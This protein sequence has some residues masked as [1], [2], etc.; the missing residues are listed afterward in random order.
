[1]ATEGVAMAGLLQSNYTSGEVRRLEKQAKDV[2]QARGLLAIAAVLDG[3][4]RMDRQT[5]RNWVLRP[6]IKDRTVS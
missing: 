2:A 3:A 6:M 1:M 5:L 4:S